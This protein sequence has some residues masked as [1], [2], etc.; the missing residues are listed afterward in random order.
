MLKIGGQ[1]TGALIAVLVLLGV[2][3]CTCRKITWCKYVAPCHVEAAHSMFIVLNSRSSRCQ[4]TTVDGF[5]NATNIDGT[6][7]LYL[8]ILLLEEVAPMKIEKNITDA[9]ERRMNKRGLNCVGFSGVIDCPGT[10]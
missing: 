2:T 10:T 8:L 3:L 5:F 6:G 7:R 4:K 9:L 1:R